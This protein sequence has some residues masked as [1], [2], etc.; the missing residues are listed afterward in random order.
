M[1]E[2]SERRRLSKQ[3][4]LISKFSRNEAEKLIHSGKV[5]VNGEKTKSA[6]AFVSSEDKIEIRGEILQKEP[7][8][9]KVIAFNK[10]RGFVVT[11]ND[12]KGRKTIY[13]IL[14]KAFANYIYVGR[15]DI[16][17][18]GLILLTNSGKLAH[19]LES[20]Q[21]GFEREYEVR[22]F[23]LVSDDKINRMQKGV[24]IDGLHYKAKTVFI[25]KRRTED[26]RNTWLTV[27]LETG[28]NREVRNLMEFFNLKVN[29]LLSVRYAN[30]TLSGLPLGAY[31][32]L[33]RSK[34]AKVIELVEEKCKKELTF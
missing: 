27:I 26:S 22:V 14:P 8:E 17:T 18:E 21:N 4:S 5:F 2:V 23:G 16:N 32:E 9:I 13:S 1:S 15:L 19:E 25:K 28:K 29:K 30:I 11:K 33:H 34:L 31:L 7:T 20:P 24:T 10:P 3:V 6:T 12:E